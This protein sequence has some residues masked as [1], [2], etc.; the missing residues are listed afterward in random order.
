[1]SSRSEVVFSCS[2]STLS[3]PAALLYLSAAI[4]LILAFVGIDEQLMCDLVCVDQ[5]RRLNSFLI[6]CHALRLLCVRSVDLVT[7]YLFLF[8][9]FIVSINFIPVSS[10]PLPK[11]LLEYCV[12]MFYR[13]FYLGL[14]RE[15]GMYILM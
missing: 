3:M 13:W 14:L 6:V 8:C 4:P 12:C 9:Y 10:V 15:T 5:T 11:G 7:S 1:M 2:T